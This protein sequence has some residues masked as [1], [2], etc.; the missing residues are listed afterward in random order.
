MV[1][2][3]NA[4]EP[5]PASEAHASFARASASAFSSAASAACWRILEARL[6]AG[7]PFVEGARFSLADIVLGLS[8][9]RW[10]TTPITRADLPHVTAWLGR[11]RSRAAAAHYLSA[12]FP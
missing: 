4:H 8:A 7:G 12:R 9:H 10:Q 1:V 2:G 5:S 6:A 3:S 11:L